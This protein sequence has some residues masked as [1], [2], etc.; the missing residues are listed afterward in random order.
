MSLMS[1][2][3]FEPGKGSSCIE[4][5]GVKIALTV[6]EDLWNEGKTPC[7]TTYPM[8]ALVMQS[9]D[10]MINIAASPFDYDHAEERLRVLRKNVQKYKLPLLYVN[11]VGRTRPN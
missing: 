9:P 4:L 2:A 10:L 11:H 8:D 3:I 7:I 1:I 6:C 5:D